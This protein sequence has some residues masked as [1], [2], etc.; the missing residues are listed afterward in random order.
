MT[1]NAADLQEVPIQMMS[2][3]MIRSA[4]CALAKASSVCAIAGLLNMPVHAQNAFS[5]A[6]IV[7]DSAVTFFEIEQRARL[8]VIMSAP[9]DPLELAREQLI[10][11]RLK[12]Q[13]ARQAGIAPSEEGIVSGL[14]NFAKRVNM[15]PEDMLQALAAEG[16]SEEALRDFL[17]SQIA[18]GGVVQTRFG[19]NAQVSEEEIDRAIAQSSGQGGVR[20]LL[21]EIIIPVTPQTKAQVDSL[22][23]QISELSSF[24]E[25]ESAARIYSASG[26]K[27]NGGHVDWMN[28]TNLPA[29]LRPVIS[30]LR[31]GEVT[32]PLQLPNAIAL[33]QLRGIAE[34]GRS[35]PRY[36]AIDYAKFY[37]PGGRSEEALKEATRVRSE[38]DKCD[39]LYGV[40]HG[41]PAERLFRETQKPNEIPRD[42]AI[43][44]AKL[45]DNEISTNLTSADGQNLIVLMLCGRTAE[46]N[47]A[48][49]SREDV[50][51]SLRNL[52][53]ESYANS[54][55][56]QLRAQARIIE[57]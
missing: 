34:T 53:L 8:L 2:R 21:S 48:E 43:E 32:P 38:V 39:D 10:E 37:I 13:A 7:N 5:P 22:A 49:L 24:S 26:T 20:V 36:S 25:F 55:L 57:K 15:K 19:A 45:D 35:T 28:V 6:V 33:F 11:D 46:I 41:L 17:S 3:T 52:R 50:A 18:W 14:E 27:E 47:D 1:A 16:I 9:G 51:Q 54:Y 30:G 4:L 44:L 29:P 56:S 42:V 40:G 31:K 12:L 23:A